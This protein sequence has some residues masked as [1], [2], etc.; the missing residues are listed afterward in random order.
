MYIG[1]SQMEAR[2]LLSKI[3]LEVDL[4]HQCSFEQRGLKAKK[5]LLQ[6]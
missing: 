5:R 6:Y 3:S 1:L 2:I 4:D